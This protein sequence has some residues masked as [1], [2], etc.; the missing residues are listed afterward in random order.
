MSKLELVL[1]FTDFGTEIAN[2]G[3]FIGFSVRSRFFHH[4][5]GFYYG[6]DPDGE[7]VYT[8]IVDDDGDFCS[9]KVESFDH[10]LPTP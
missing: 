1:S 3:G 6:L 7:S 5:D 8:F 10:Y 9:I 2:D 4:P